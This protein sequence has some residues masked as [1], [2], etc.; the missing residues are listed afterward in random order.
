MIGGHVMRLNFVTLGVTDLDAARAFY[1]DGL[2]WKPL[3]DVPG[4]VIFFQVGPGLTLGLYTGLEGDVGDGVALADPSRAPLSL[5]HNVDTDDAVRD[6]FAAAVEAGARPLK[7]P[8]RADFGGFHAYFADPA[9]FRWE[10]CHNPGWS[11]AEDGT[12]SIGSSS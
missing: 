8:Q 2:G 4:E 5:S 10:I 11:V 1:V 3:L 6:L 12:V 9:G 7:T